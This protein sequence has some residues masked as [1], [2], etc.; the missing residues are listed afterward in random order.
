[1][2]RPLRLLGAVLTAVALLGCAPLGLASAS[3]SP[4]PFIP[5]PKYLYYGTSK[6]Q[7]IIPYKAKTPNSKLVALIHGGGWQSSELSWNKR[8]AADLQAAGFA[9]AVVNY[10]TDSP[11]VP[12]FPLEPNEVVQ[13]IAYAMAHASA[14]NA[15]STVID[16]VGGSAG[17][18]IGA[19]AA[20]QLNDAKSGTVG[21]VLTLSGAMDFTLYN[22]TTNLLDTTQSVALGCPITNCPVATEAAASPAKH[23]T[24]TNCPTNW[25]LFNSTIEKTP[26]AQPQAMLAAL[27]AAHCN[28][29]LVT[30]NGI[31][32]S[33][34]YWDKELAV[35]I[36]DL[37]A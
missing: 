36:A 11:T 34:Q 7:Y 13:G 30:I 16:L 22:S 1:M 31:D 14:F 26:L 23:I 15:N 21:K 19:L 12:A 29:S 28:A 9:V 24:S 18:T 27:Q 4:A 5:N 3:A 33:W 20:E 35:I 2:L 37:K 17:S 8:E 25:V 10:D 32:H 6:L